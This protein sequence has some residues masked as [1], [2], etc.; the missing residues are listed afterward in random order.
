MLNRKFS[1]S[2]SSSTRNTLGIAPEVYEKLLERMES[3]SKGN[4]IQ[5][6]R[7]QHQRIPYHSPFLNISLTSRQMSRTNICVATRNISRSGVSVLHSNFVHTGTGTS[8]TLQRLDSSTVTVRGTV[9][10]CQHISGIVHE[11]GIKFDVPIHPQEF[12]RFLP[13][14]SFRSVTSVNPEDLSGNVDII[15]SEQD[16]F[17][18]FEDQ[19][20]ETNIHLQSFAN[21]DEFLLTEPSN[22]RVVIIVHERPTIDG[23][24]L[25]HKLRAGEY[26]GPLILA[27]VADSKQEMGAFQLSSADTF[28]AMP[29]DPDDL[30]AALGEFLLY[31]WKTET[32]QR[33]RSH[34]DPEAIQ[35]IQDEFAKISVRLDQLL[36]TK[37]MEGILNQ[38]MI[39]ESISPLVGARA[40][41]DL[42]HQLVEALQ[43]SAD[44]EQ[45][46]DQISETRLLI[47][48]MRNAA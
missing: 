24:K 9:V 48:N 39:L 2:T 41:T 46:E 6:T 44:F 7:R 43:E 11:I 8:V 36:R 14:D 38:C 19:L 20:V 10:R 29:F 12:I 42:S 37:N 27:G 15:T 21:A 45:I 16:K 25:A 32:L 13:L 33:I 47:S 17:G 30:Y 3:N 26:N 34:K 35:I 28:L 5:D 23:P 18:L 40:L 31:E 22:E 1:N 4:E